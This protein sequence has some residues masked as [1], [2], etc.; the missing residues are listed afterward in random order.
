MTLDQIRKNPVFLSGAVVKT[1]QNNE[2]FQDTISKILER[3]YS[4]D[5]GAIPPEDMAANVSDLS[6]S[7]GRIV[8]RYTEA[9]GL[10]EDV[11]IIAYFCEDNS[12]VDYNYT[13]ILYTTDY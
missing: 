5:F 2:A 4:G 10:P 9:D 11:Y 6:Y 7:Q 3:F 1:Y 8:A 13:S 12:G